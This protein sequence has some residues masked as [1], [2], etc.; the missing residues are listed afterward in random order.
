MKNSD[1]QGRMDN[2]YVNSRQYTLGGSYALNN[3][4]LFAGYNLRVS[5]GDTVVTAE[6]PYEATRSQMA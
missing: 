5:S 6:T 2:L 1:D 3:L 4:R